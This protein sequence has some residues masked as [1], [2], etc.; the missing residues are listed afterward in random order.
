MKKTV[1]RLA[2]LF[3]VAVLLVS[4][5]V[6]SVFAENAGAKGQAV[7]GSGSDHKDFLFFSGTR[8]ENGTKNALWAMPYTPTFQTSIPDSMTF[9]PTYAESGTDGDQNFLRGEGR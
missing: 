7:T 4:G 3:A 6:F 2:L 9:W 5:I 1:S 8:E